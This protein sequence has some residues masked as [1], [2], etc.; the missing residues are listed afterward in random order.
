MA[1][2]NLRWT[3]DVRTCLAFVMVETLAASL[4]CASDWYVDQSYS[5][6]GTGSGGPNDPFCTIGDALNV[7]AD[8]DTIHIAPGSY[9]EAIRIFSADVTLVGTRGPSVTKVL[10]GNPGLSLLRVEQGAS[11]RVIGLSFEHGLSNLD[12]GGVYVTEGSSLSLEDCVVADCAAAQYGYGGGIYN[13]G[14][15]KMLRTTLRGNDAYYGGGLFDKSSGTQ[16]LRIENCVITGNTASWSGGVYLYSSLPARIDATTISDNDASA[17]G[18][19]MGVLAQDIELWN[20]TISGNTAR[21][22]GALLTGTTVQSPPNVRFFH[23]KVSGNRADDHGGT[24]SQGTLLFWS[25]TVAGNV[26]TY[27]SGGGIYSVSGTVFIG[28]T[29]VAD[30]SAQMGPDCYGTLTSTGYNLIED[31]ADCTIIGDPTGNL[32]GVDPLLSGLADNGGRTMTHHLLPGSPARDAGD[33]SITKGK[34]QRGGSRV[35][36]GNCDGVAVRDM[37]AVEAGLTLI[38]EPTTLREGDVGELLTDDGEPFTYSLLIITAVDGIE[39]SFPIDFGLLSDQGRR[40]ISMVVPPGLSG[41]SMKLRAFA[42]DP[43]FEPRGSDP[44]RIDFR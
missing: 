17:G 24:D 35:L 19:G 18:G 11:A 34:D 36:D 14:S 16:G 8:G 44:V 20:C 32:L 6:C 31:T 41:R 26:A 42:F 28:H 39:T 33:P 12:G 2:P 3:H 40:S 15:L 9:L 22:A 1:H 23:C 38:A 27:G 4:A 5:G 43:C 21:S 30:N 29:V 10:Y 37:G 13:L 7:A 25:S